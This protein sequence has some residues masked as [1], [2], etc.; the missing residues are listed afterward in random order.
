MYSAI[1]RNKIMPF[2]ATW[3]DLEMLILSEVSQRRT[4][5]IRYHIYME[6]NKKWYKWAYIKNRNTD[7]KI[8]LMVTKG[9][10]WGEVT[11]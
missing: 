3:V 11:N 4:S 1:E 10:K 2:A 9:D 6:S 5:I 8:K 7:L